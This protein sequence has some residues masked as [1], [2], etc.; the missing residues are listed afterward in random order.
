MRMRSELLLVVGCLAAGVLCRAAARRT[1]PTR[2]RGLA[3]REREALWTAERGERT[4]DVVIVGYRQP[5]YSR[6]S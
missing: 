5:R 3:P 6:H 1:A 4:H 2:A